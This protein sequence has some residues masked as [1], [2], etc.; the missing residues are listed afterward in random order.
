MGQEEQAQEA[1]KAVNVAV[2]LGFVPRAWQ[3][4]CIDAMRK[5]TVLVVHRRAGKTVL[6]A[7]TLF[8][9]A[10]KRPGMY[11]YVMPELKQGRI[12]AWPVF[13]SILRKLQG[14]QV[15]AAHKI[16]LARA[17]ESDNSI[18]F[19]NGSEIKLLGSDNPDSIRGAKLA[20]VVMDEVAQMPREVWTEVIMPALLDSNGWALFIGTPKGINLFSELFE[21]GNDPAFPNWTSLVFTVYETD[22]LS[23]EQI[24]EYKAVSS[25]EEFKREML[26]DFTASTEDQLI[27]IMDVAMAME[28]YGEQG[29]KGELRPGRG[30]NLILG[31][32]VSRYGNDRSVIFARAG[33]RAELVV[34]FTG[35]DT[36]QL[37]DAVKQAY[38]HYRPAAIYVDGTGVGGGV[39]D[40]LR[41]RRIPCYDVN[42][43]SSSAEAIYN[44]K[45]T[46]IWC[47]M[48][49]WIKSKGCLNPNCD[50]LKIDLCAPLYSRAENGVYALEAKKDIRRRI[51]LSPDLGDALALTFT[52]YVPEIEV[53]ERDCVD[54]SVSKIKPARYSP[55]EQFERDMGGA[56]EHD[57]AGRYGQVYGSHATLRARMGWPF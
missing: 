13:K 48:A 47:R 7:Q 2:D 46:E 17:Y 30:E 20:G 6:A 22:A 14:L 56:N 31:V 36:A 25:E 5:Y 32:D 51:G 24:A 8:S 15:D 1:A 10:L 43:S 28:R 45:R 35:K 40:I 37:A 26:C 18:R 12:V 54:M 23:A 29:Y 19:N 55:F 44:N 49:Q 3:Q 39:V 50:A 9:Y 53:S 27:S 42:F 34:Q 52:D 21:R 16:D 33:L 11:A 57:A 38:E 41:A 4:N